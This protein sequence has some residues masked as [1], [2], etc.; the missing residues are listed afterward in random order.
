[1]AVSVTLTTVIKEPLPSTRVLI[2]FSDGTQ[3]EFGT[4]AE[5]REYIADLET[6]DTARRLFLGWWL[7]RSPDGS[8]TAIV[9]GKTL[10]F[11]LSN[12]NPIRVQ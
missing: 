6:N 5:L 4:F 1:M 3:L 11:N 9:E 10:T 7:G 12:P 8:S 2:N